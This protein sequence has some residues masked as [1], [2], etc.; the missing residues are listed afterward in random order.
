ME[1]GTLSSKNEAWR[2]VNLSFA[3]PARFGKSR[4]MQEVIKHLKLEKDGLAPDLI[5]EIE[6]AVGLSWQNEKLTNRPS[7]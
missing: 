4:F 1:T 3:G 5:R 7:K 2:M 6:S